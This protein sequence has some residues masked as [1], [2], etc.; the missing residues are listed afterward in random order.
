[1]LSDTTEDTQRFLRCEL[2]GKLI[3]EYNAANWFMFHSLAEPSYPMFACDECFHPDSKESY[4]RMGQKLIETIP[5][6][7]PLTAE[8]LGLV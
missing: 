7:R 3:P 4:Q 5:P 2:C 1:M 6:P 8:E